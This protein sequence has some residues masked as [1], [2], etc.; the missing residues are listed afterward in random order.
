[1]WVI[2]FESVTPLAQ[3]RL[4]LFTRP[5]VPPEVS[6][7]GRAGAGGVGGG[8]QGASLHNEGA[9][10]GPSVAHACMYVF[11]L[12]CGI[13]RSGPL[14]CSAEQQGAADLGSRPL[15][16]AAGPCSAHHSP[17]CVP[18][19]GLRPLASPNISFSTRPPRS[20]RPAP[21][22]PTLSAARPTP[23]PLRCHSWRWV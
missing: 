22:S 2:D 16:P 15:P 8:K 23:G 19:P 5:Y 20:S 17:A 4:N 18:A 12:A 9:E 10:G 7:R 1:M 21:T 14:Q 11:S 13:L 3:P 6:E